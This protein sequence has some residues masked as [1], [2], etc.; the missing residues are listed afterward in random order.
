MERLDR[1][2]R[3]TVY[4]VDGPCGRFGIR[5]DQTCPELD[6]LLAPHQ[7]EA[8]AFVTAYNPGSVPTDDARN[9]QR[10]ADLERVIQ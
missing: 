2:Y 4:R 7:A 5:V 10:Q 6:Q 9:R 3:A 1:T 8:W